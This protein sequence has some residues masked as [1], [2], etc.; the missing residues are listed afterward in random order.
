MVNAYQHCAP[1][2]CSPSGDW[3]PCQIA[4]CKDS[5]QGAKP[6]TPAVL[7]TN[8]NRIMF[9]AEPLS[10]SSSLVSALQSASSPTYSSAYPISS[11]LLDGCDAVIGTNLINFLLATNY[12]N[13]PYFVFNTTCPV[14]FTQFYLRNTFN[15]AS[16][17]RYRNVL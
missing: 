17:D 3:I 12:A 7:K 11:A 10:S 2:K 6:A 5:A 15:G 14:T 13:N 9:L 1:L 8:F 16:N 4:V